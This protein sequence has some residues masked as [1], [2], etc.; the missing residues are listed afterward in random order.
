MTNTK[1]KPIYYFNIIDEE[2]GLPVL[3]YYNCDKEKLCKAQ[4][5]LISTG[6]TCSGIQEA[7]HRYYEAAYVA[8]WGCFL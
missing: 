5:Q 6:L 2:K 4:L 3:N 8:K 1:T 7:T